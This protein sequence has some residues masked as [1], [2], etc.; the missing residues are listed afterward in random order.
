MKDKPAILGVGPL[1]FMPSVL[2]ALAML[3]VHYLF[4]PFFSLRQ[5]P[6]IYFVVSALVLLV[7]GTGMVLDAAR[8]L[9]RGI[10]EGKLVTAGI[11]AATRNPLYAA[12]IYF[13]APGIV[14][15]FRSWLLFSVPLVM[16]VFFRLFIRREELW[17][18]QNFGGEYLEYKNNVGLLF[19]K[20]WRSNS[21][22]SSIW[23]RVAGK[24]DAITQ[25]VKREV[26]FYR[27]VLNH[28]RTPKPAK[29]LLAAALAYALSPVDLIPDWIPV[30]G[31]LD[32]LIIVPVLV[33][34]AFRM[35]PP[36]VVQECRAETKS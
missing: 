20:L 21:S 19:P 6:H 26:R 36:S 17:L 24:L 28:A 11:Y 33:I 8:L 12:Y 7:I 23:G 9:I 1:I 34:F 5:I 13:I 16:Y 27:A 29:W 3:G 25:S 14:L 22:S 2:F 31:H 32:D 4:Y 35:V 30:I 15:L 18:E 10:R